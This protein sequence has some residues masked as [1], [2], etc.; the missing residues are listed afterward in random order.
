MATCRRSSVARAALRGVLAGTARS[1]FGSCVA[2]S[3]TVL[4]IFRLNLSGG[5]GGTNDRSWAGHRSRAICRCRRFFSRAALL[6]SKRR[7]DRLHVW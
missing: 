4:V 7:V 5:L 6:R 1:A 2:C 3:G